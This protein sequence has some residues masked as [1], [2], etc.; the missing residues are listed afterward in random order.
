MNNNVCLETRVVVKLS[1]KHQEDT[2][3]KIVKMYI[4]QYNRENTLVFDEIDIVGCGRKKSDRSFL[5]VFRDN[6]ATLQDRSDKI[7]GF[8]TEIIRNIKKF[9]TIWRLRLN[10]RYIP[11]FISIKVIES[12][13]VIYQQEKHYQTIIIPD[14]EIEELSV[15]YKN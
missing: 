1:D 9:K 11:Q 10:I 15:S 13:L 6:T 7:F 2:F 4:D 8:V 3:A 12:R 14:N 5:L